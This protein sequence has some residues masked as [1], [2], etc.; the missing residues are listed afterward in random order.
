MNDADS[1]FPGEGDGKV[2][3]RHGIHRGTHDG[4]V[5]ADFSGYLGAGVHLCRED[6][7]IAGLQKDVVEGEAILET[8]RIHS[9]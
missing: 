7:A 8:L 9:G 3:L 6:I 1:P 5:Q 4:N 2:G